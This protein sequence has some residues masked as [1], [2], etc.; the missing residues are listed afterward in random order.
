MSTE[1]L[2]SEIIADAM[3]QYMVGSITTGADLL[4]IRHMVGLDQITFAKLIG[5]STSAIMRAEDS[6]VLPRDIA[7][8][9]KGVMIEHMSN[10]ALQHMREMQISPQDRAVI[11]RVFCTR[12]ANE[13]RVECAA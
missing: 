7:L 5:K 11:A 13:L 10:L 1:V 2:M 4:Q 3:R 8:L 6:N 12:M 9:A